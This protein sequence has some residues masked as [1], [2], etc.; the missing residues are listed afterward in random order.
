MFNVELKEGMNVETADGR[1]LGKINRFI[2]NPETNEVTHIVVEKGWLLGEDKVVPFDKVRSTDE[3]KV[4][5][6]Q[7]IE[8]FDDLPP[9]EEN[10]YVR[11][12]DRDLESMST[13]RAAD[14]PGYP[15]A[16]T[17]YW[18][19]PYGSF[20]YPAYGLAAYSWPRTETVQNIPEDTVPLKE[21]TNV[22][23]SDDKHVGDIERLFLETGSNKATHVLISEGI[24]F[25]DRRLI[26]ASWIRSA[27]EE[28]VQLNVPSELLEGLPSYKE[29]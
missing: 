23:S 22:M 1:E 6:S 26:P 24:F 13:N 11:A 25:K 21:G 20:G 28:S 7:E 9:F 3:D 10:Y 14:R 19:P 27:T 18:Y 8:D 2:L 12:D 16:P 29:D 4:V 15:I 17:Y 5:L